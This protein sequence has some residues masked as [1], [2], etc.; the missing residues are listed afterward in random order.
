MKKIVLIITT[1]LLLIAGCNS[2]EKIDVKKEKNSL[3]GIYTP[4][5]VAIIYGDSRSN[6]AEYEEA[7]IKIV[8]RILEQKPSIVFNNGD[9]V[10]D[11]NSLENWKNFEVLIERLKMSAEYFPVIGNHELGENRKKGLTNFF[12]IFPELNY[13]K[14]YSIEKN[15]I[16]FIVL[17][18][19]DQYK[20]Q[21]MGEIKIGSKQYEWLEKELKESN[22]ELF[23]VV[24]FHIPL[25]TSGS[26]GPTLWAR[27]LLTPLFEKHSVDLVFTSHDHMYERSLYNGIPY[28]LTGGG[29]VETREISGVNE[30]SMKALKS[31]HICRLEIIDNKLEMNVIDIDGKEIDHIS[32]SK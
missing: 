8:D 31:Q 10:D 20:E 3:T 1:F 5:K 2:V 13:R 14:W 30:Y 26:H 16:K 22:P 18:I 15:G 4:K 19:P 11:G 7:H 17:Y 23:K 12:N 28:I 21:N 32:I 9:L 25:F 6:G 24:M 27:D 29:G